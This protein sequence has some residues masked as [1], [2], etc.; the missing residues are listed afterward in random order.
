MSCKA[1]CQYS[2]LSGGKGGG[3]PQASPSHWYMLQNP[4]WGLLLTTCSY[5]YTAGL[6]LGAMPS[7]AVLPTTLLPASKGT[8]AKGN[9]ESSVNTVP[10][11]SAVNGKEQSKSSKAE[12]EGSGVKASAFT[13]GEG[14]AVIPA[15]VVNRIIRGEFVDMAELLV[16][17]IELDE[18]LPSVWT[19]ASMID[20]A[21]KPHTHIR[22]RDLQEDAQGL[23]SWVEAVNVFACIV[24][25]RFPELVKPLAAYQTLIVKEAHRFNY[26]GWLQYDQLF[27]Q[28]SA[29][30]VKERIE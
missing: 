2:T 9:A 30:G 8:G 6:P 19:A 3:G 25:E 12:S 10:P 1:R 18:R 16:D 29:A 14:F 20:G 13:L 27:C 5:H 26:R 21:L 24:T 11:P 23:F 22:M 4:G 17:N 28:H 15:K 7:P